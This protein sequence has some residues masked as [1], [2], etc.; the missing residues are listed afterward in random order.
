MGVRGPIPKSADIRILEG[1]RAHRPLPESRP[2]YA[3]VPE[4]PKG[5]TA[6]ARRIWD[7]YLAQL[8]G[9]LRMVDGFALRRLCEDVA[10]L[11]ELQVGLRKMAGEMRRAARTDAERLKA[12]DAQLA[13]M[14]DS[15]SDERAQ[16]ETER[17][18]ISARRL[19]GGAMIS[20][21]KTHEGR[22]IT[23]TISSLASR[24]SRQEMQ[25]GLTPASSA[26]IGDG[27]GLPR[28]A[29]MERNGI[30]EALCG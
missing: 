8:P 11:E 28:L 30:E 16:L 13:L 3:G 15:Q 17:L 27:I 14:P 10:L 24:I 21:A 4:R 20:L 29:S 5:M 2:V 19:S 25:F 1:Q 22:R 18:E 9:A 26:R 6:A 23:A 7:S 12:L